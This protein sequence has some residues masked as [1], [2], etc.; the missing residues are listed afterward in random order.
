MN[1]RNVGVE[2]LSEL[3]EKTI[4]DFVQGAPPLDDSTTV[5]LKRLQ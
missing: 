3:L 1:N 2:E 4:R 5:L